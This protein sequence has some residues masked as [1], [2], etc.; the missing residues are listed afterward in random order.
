L[1]CIAASSIKKH[2]HYGV[3]NASD[4][5]SNDNGLEQWDSK[6]NTPQIGQITKKDHDKSAQN[7]AN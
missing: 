3:E 4:A 7:P 1:G 5:K 2:L 6:E